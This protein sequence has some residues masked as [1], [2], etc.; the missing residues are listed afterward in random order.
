[1]MLFDIACRNNRKYSENSTIIDSFCTNR[2]YAVHG[3]FIQ[4]VQKTLFLM[5][6]I[7]EI[8]E[9]GILRSGIMVD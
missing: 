8:P 1:M 7:V 6:I 5:E 3:M 4:K 2:I 9:R